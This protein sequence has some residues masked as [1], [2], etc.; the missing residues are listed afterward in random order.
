MKAADNGHVAAQYTLG[1]MLL[2]GTTE[3]E[4]SIQS[5]IQYLTKAAEADS[6]FAMYTLGKAYLT[7]E[8]RNTALA[9]SY[10]IRAASGGND[11]ANYLLGK[12][13]LF[14]PDFPKKRSEGISILKSCA[15]RGNI[16]AELSLNHLQNRMMMNLFGSIG[17]LFCNAFRQT[18]PPQ[19]A[20]PERGVDRRLKRQIQL[21][22]KGMNYEE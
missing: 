20:D 19:Q 5:G 22:K 14:D 21:K 3:V 16:Y 13:Y 17:S 8:L 10:L 9:E 11:N 7:P 12:T 6:T 2:N 4:R 18:P 1:K 15:D